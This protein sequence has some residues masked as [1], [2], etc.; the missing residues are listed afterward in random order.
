MNPAIPGTCPEGDLANLQRVPAEAVDLRRDI[1]NFVRFVEQ[2]GLLRTKRENSI[3]KG[4]ARKLAKL[5]SYAGE[6]EAVDE[7][8]CGFWSNYVSYV[9]REMGLVSFDS[10]GIYQGYSST[11]P[12]FPDNHVLVSTEDW[13]DYLAKSPL[14]KERAILAALISISPNEFFHR[15]TLV[16]GENFESY[17]SATGPARLM[18]LPRIRRGLLDFLATLQ[19]DVWYEFRD[20]VELLKERGP[21]LILDPDTREPDAASTR[22]LQDWKWDR[23]RK[24]KGLSEKPELVLES[25]YSNFREY[26]PRTDSWERGKATQ[27]TRNTRNAFH[28]V[29]G[30]FLEYFLRQIPYL[31]GFVEL[32]YRNADDPHG[33]KVCPRFE[34][35]RAFRLT[36]RFFDVVQENPE[37]NRTK[38]TVLPNFEI[39]LESSSYPDAALV[40]LAPFTSLLSVDG[41]MVKLRL[42]K[43]K[44]VDFAAQN[45]DAGSA[46]ELLGELIDSPLPGNVAAEL[47]AWCARGER[48]TVYAGFSLLEFLGTTE[49]RKEIL[50]QLGAEVVDD[51]IEHF[52]LIRNQELVFNALETRGHVP[53]AVL[54]RNDGFVSGPGRLGVAPDRPTGTGP[55][56]KVKPAA[57]VTVE[58]EDLIGYRASDPALMIALNEALKSHLNTCILVGDNLLIVSASGLP[59]LR[60]ALRRLEDQFTVTIQTANSEGE[61]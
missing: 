7:D 14:A 61:S 26:P 1:F 2:F 29:E 57:T 8:G 34:A 17:G 13:E 51:G 37:F 33:T 41:P 39:L 5:L 15:A 4:V 48:L 25:I 16:A 18:D 59:K 30:R 35:L 47:T 19:P 49:E 36:R 20:V 42:Q 22:R 31:C 43:K 24:K 9:A 12:S 55:G 50:T 52:A 58:S 3:P 10:K 54:H 53:L 46:V 45:P 60:A 56:K 44:V 27:I 32:G 21:N 28:R 11:S 40:S 38:I 6:V 23:R